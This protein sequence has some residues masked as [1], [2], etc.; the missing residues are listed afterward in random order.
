MNQDFDIH[1]LKNAIYEAASVIKELKEGVQ[2]FSK[3][4]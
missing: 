4:A 2:V 1:L 3:T